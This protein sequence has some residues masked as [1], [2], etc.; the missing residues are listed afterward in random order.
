MSLRTLSSTDELKQALDLFA[1]VL[2]RPEFPAA[3]LERE[4]ARII[5]AIKEAD[6]KPEV[7][8]NRN[9]N[10]LIYGRSSVWPAQLRRSPKRLL[11]SRATIWSGFYRRYY[12]ADQ[13]VVAIIGNL[14]RGEAEALADQLTA[15]LPRSSAPAVIPEVPP[16]TRAETRAIAHPATQSHLLIGAPGIKR[17]DP[18]YFPLFVGNYILGGGGFVSRITE[19]VRSKRGLAY[20]AYSYFSPMKERGVRS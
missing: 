11:R 3:V 16:L 12:T 6:T 7:I 1:R 19:E 18:D 2:Q 10:A 9:F 8:L 13:A 14:G 20:S 4:K 5:G 17:D 15:G